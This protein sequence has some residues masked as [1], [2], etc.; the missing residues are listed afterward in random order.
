MSLSCSDPLKIEEEIKTSLKLLTDMLQAVHKVDDEEK[1][2]PEKEMPYLVIINLNNELV[3]FFESARNQIEETTSKIVARMYEE[4]L[5]R[6]EEI[7]NKI[8]SLETVFMKQQCL[9]SSRRNERLNE[10]NERLFR[11]AMAHKEQEL[12][13]LQDGMKDLKEENKILTHRVKNY[14]ATIEQLMKR[15]EKL[16][17]EKCKK[18]EK[19]RNNCIC[20][21]K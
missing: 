8:K 5:G 20:S 10:N 12:N 18:C 2:E 17:I 13:N 7:E 3:K 15:L 14:D 21:S 6:R 19:S 11:E 9:A 4:F 1:T 16:E